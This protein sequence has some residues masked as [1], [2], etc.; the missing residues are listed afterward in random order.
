M[1]IKGRNILD[2]AVVLNEAVEDARKTK[3]ERMVFKVD[4]AKASDS[5]DWEYIFSM[6]RGMNFPLEWIRWISGCITSASANVLVNGIPS[7]EFKLE[8]GFRQGDPLSPFLF[9]VVAEGLNVL[10]KRAIREGLL[11]AAQLGRDKVAISHIQYTDDTAFVVEG[12]KE[13][14]VALKWLL[15]NFEL[16]SGLKVNFE[17]S[18]VFGINIEEGNL[19]EIYDI[20]GCRVGDG[21][22]PYLGLSIGGRLNGVDGWTKVIDKLKKKL[23]GWNAKS[24]SLGGRATLVQACLSSIPLYWMS[25]SPLPKAVERK[26]RSLQRNFLWGGD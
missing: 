9:L 10:T 18:S 20:L 12:N 22:I 2:G 15:K 13:N 19:R 17:K 25:F 21:A 23:R 6:M 14:A 5:V 7:G 11:Q 24:M 3:K 8:R 1:F 4:F 16:L 26:I